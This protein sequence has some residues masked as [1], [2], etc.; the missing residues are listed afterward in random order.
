[1]VNVPLVGRRI[2][3]CPRRHSEEGE[4]LGAATGERARRTNQLCPGETRTRNEDHQPAG[5]GL[6]VGRR[7]TGD[8]VEERFE[9]DKSS[10][11]GCSAD[12]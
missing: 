3:G 2:G 5:D 11:Q 12:D 6:Q 9:E 10:A 8:K 4:G 1:M 7:G